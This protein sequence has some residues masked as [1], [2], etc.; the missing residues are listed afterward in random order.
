LDTYKFSGPLS[1]GSGGWAPIHFAA[2]EGNLPILNSLLAAGEEVDRLTTE[3][4]AEFSSFAGC[5]PL[6]LVALYVPDSSLAVDVAKSLLSMRASAGATQMGRTLLNFAAMG[7]ARGPDLCAFLLDHGVSIEQPC[8]FGFTPLANACNQC[9]A[10]SVFQKPEKVKY[11]IDK[12]AD[13][14]KTLPATGENALQAV[15]PYA[16]P[17]LIQHMLAAGAS[18]LPTKTLREACLSEVWYHGMGAMTASTTVHMTYLRAAR[19][20]SALHS[21]AFFGNVA[22]VEELLKS[23]VDPRLQNTAGKT[24]IEVARDGSALPVVSYL[25][26]VSANPPACS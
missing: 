16:Q 8:T 17:P 13:P 11:L 22:A 6:A 9:P 18:P 25:E 20:G 24:A 3:E 2:L 23:G 1:L 10:G 12:R 21:A 19:G 5:T 7:A 14:N 26:G 15:A 4:H